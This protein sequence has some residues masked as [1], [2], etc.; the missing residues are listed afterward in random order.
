MH[1]IEK[2]ENQYLE[3]LASIIT[4]DEATLTSDLTDKVYEGLEKTYAIIAKQLR[5]IYGIYFK[6]ATSQ[7]LH[8]LCYNRDG[9]TISERIAQH[10]EDYKASEDNPIRSVNL[11]YDM[12]RILHTDNVCVVNNLIYNKLKDE[13]QAVKVLGSGGCETCDCSTKWGTYSIESFQ[14]DET[15]LMPPFHP[16]CSC[17]I[18]M[19]T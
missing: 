1:K 16:E 11:L 10:V 4:K 17:F 18:I 9:K 6:P 15:N 7:E 19:V 13:A 3:E 12:Q 2:S 14:A 8:N 5:E